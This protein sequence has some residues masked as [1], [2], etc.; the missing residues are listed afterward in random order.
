MLFRSAR[1]RARSAESGRHRHRSFAGG[2]ERLK[3]LQFVFFAP[4]NDPRVWL[5]GFHPDVRAAEVIARDSTPQREYGHAGTAPLLDIQGDNG[6]YRPRSS[7]NKLV[8]ESGAKR[9]SVVVIPR[10]A[11]AIIVEQPRT[12]ADAIIG[13]VRRL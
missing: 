3:H 5:A 8:Q 12:V 13:W 11:H 4:G 2:G 1:F 7:A 6:P 9:V 10:A